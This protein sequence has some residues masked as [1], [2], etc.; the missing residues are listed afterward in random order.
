MRTD[1]TAKNQSF[2]RSLKLESDKSDERKAEFKGEEKSD[3]PN[4]KDR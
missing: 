1:E 2:W 4:E 3:S